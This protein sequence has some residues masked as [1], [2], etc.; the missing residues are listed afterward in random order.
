MAY[1][2]LYGNI[3]VVCHLLA[4]DGDDAAVDALDP[5]PPD[6]MISVMT[7]SVITDISD[8]SISDARDALPPDHHQR[9]SRWVGRGHL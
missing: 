6:I 7:V 5:L 1:Q 8:D 9:V 3:A 2:K 4:P